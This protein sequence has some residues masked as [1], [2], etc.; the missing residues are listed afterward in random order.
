MKMRDKKKIPVHQVTSEFADCLE[1]AFSPKVVVS[2]GAASGGETTTFEENAVGAMSITPLSSSL[3]GQISEDTVHLSV[4][5]DWGTNEEILFRR[6]ERAQRE[7][8]N[9]PIDEEEDMD[10]EGFGGQYVDMSKVE[11]FDEPASQAPG[12]LGDYYIE[13]HG[14][15]YVELGGML[16][17]VAATGKGGGDAGRSY[18][19]YKLMNGGV[20]LFFRRDRHETVSNMWIE[21]GSIPLCIYGGL[22]NLWGEVQKVLKQEGVVIIRDIVSRVD[23]YSDFDICEVDEF[24]RR[25]YENC[26]VTRARK[27][28]KYGQ[29]ELN[30]AL[31]MNGYKH[32]GFSIGTDI[33]LRV[34]DKRYELRN[35]PI[36]WGVFADKYNGIPDV[37][38][39]VEFQLRRNALKEFEVGDGGRIE[40]VASYLPVREQLWRYLTEDWFRLTDEEVDK[41]NN[42]QSR[43]QTWTIWEAVQNAVSKAV[44]FIQRIDRK[45]KVDPAHLFKMGMGCICKAAILEA[46]S[47]IEEAQ[48]VAKY[49]WNKL[50]SYGRAYYLEVMEKHFEDLFIRC[51]GRLC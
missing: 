39:R 17:K 5:V 19:K 23:I 40:G 46:G 47:D 32:T 29:D 14:N 18:Y 44:D 30:T 48:D 22:E 34:Y 13:G 20:N 2:P 28:G 36:K 9:K 24:C 25:F 11:F 41:R 7:S 27:I 45:I 21:L 31:Y 33:K 38:T 6:L 10:T 50:K 49:F 12:E 43:A 35:D 37:L 26:K 8:Q 51:G 1:K 4:W 16:W 42:H 15:G 3:L